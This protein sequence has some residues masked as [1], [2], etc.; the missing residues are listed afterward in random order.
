M[1][2]LGGRCAW[3]PR[4]LLPISAVLPPPAQTPTLH[5]HPPLP[6]IKQIASPYMPGSLICKK[7]DPD[8]LEHRTLALQL[9]FC[10]GAEVTAG[11]RYPQINKVEI[12]L[13]ILTT[14][15]LH[16]CPDPYKLPK[17]PP[18]EPP[19]EHSLIVLEKV[20]LGTD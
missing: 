13:H 3:D 20:R 4:D 5:P 18:P 7:K 6:S 9:V 2:P 8:T 1:E 17:P 10:V 15:N 19:K 14:V 16:S 12:T 11:N